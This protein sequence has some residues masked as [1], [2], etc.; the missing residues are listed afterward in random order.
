MPEMKNHQPHL[1]VVAWV[2]HNCEFL[3]VRPLFPRTHWSR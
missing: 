3:S 1:R 2:L